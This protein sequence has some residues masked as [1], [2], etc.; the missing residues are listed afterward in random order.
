MLS[1]DSEI[2]VRA[3]AKTW[4]AAS[5][6]SGNS[7]SFSPAPEVRRQWSAA[8]E[9]RRVLAFDGPPADGGSRRCARQPAGP[10]SLARLEVV[11]L[12]ERARSTRRRMGT[13]RS[14][15]PTCPMTPTSSGGGATTG[16]LPVAGSTTQ[17]GRGSRAGCPTPRP[18]RLLPDRSRRAVTLGKCLGCWSSARSHS[19][20]RLSDG[21]G[22]SRGIE[23]SELLWT[24]LR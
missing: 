16:R 12:R 11:S 15:S 17:P 21:A 20:Y 5:C 13:P 8:P 22:G 10:G 2:C 23:R 14:S 3:T 19:P 1:Q 4:P 24:R 6:A 18:Y 7:L 9:P